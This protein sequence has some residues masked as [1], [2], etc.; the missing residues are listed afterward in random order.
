MT[1]QPQLFVPDRFDMLHRRAPDQLDSIV[2]PVEDGLERIR[3]LHRDMLAAGRG[4]FLL[5]RGDSGCGK[6]TFLNTLGLFLDGVDVLA[7]PR[8]VSVEQSL[9]TTACTSSGLRVI[10]VEGRDALRD[11]TRSDLEASVHE[12]NSFIRSERGERTLVVWSANADDLVSLLGETAQRVGADSLL[13]IGD[14]AYR[15]SGPPREQFVDIASRTIAT[16]N[17]GASLAD[18]GVS[19]ERATQLAQ[20]SATIGRFLGALR[21]DLVRNQGAVETLLQKERCR[22]WIVIAAAND[23][24]GDV[25]GLTRGTASGVDIERLMGATNANIVQELKRYPDKLGILGTV[26]DAK[27]LHL[28]SV[29]ALAVARDHADDRL[30]QSM[31]DRGLSVAG[32]GDAVNR[33]LTCDVGRAFTS[34]TMGTRTRGP[35]AGSNTETAFEKLTEIAAYYD[36]LLNV[37]VGRALVAAGLASKATPERDLGVG[38]TRV[39][40][41]LCETHSLGIVRLEFMWRRKTG[42]AD[43]ANYVLQKLHNYGRAI[44][45]LSGN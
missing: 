18:L 20:N 42:R 5:F 17:Q 40:D 2:V 33:L 11:I 25:A 43:I 26:L 14:P 27:I 23:P 37:A 19:I 44:E 30:V 45:F 36:R 24:E 38:L 31:K 21:E 28:P 4:A 41:L 9:R 10:V 29:A 35:K 34:T 8:E 13:G 16:L 22:L 3:T 7:I 15:F 39:T 6:S 32:S 12:I 1:Q